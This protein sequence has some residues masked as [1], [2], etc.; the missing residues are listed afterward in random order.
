MASFLCAQKLYFYYSIFQ[1]N[2]HQNIRIL[3][4]LPRKNFNAISATALGDYR[5]ISVCEW[6][7]GVCTLGVA[8][9]K[10]HLYYCHNNGQ[11]AGSCGSGVVMGSACWLIKSI[12]LRAFKVSARWDGDIRRIMCTIVSIAISGNSWWIIMR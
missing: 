4:H 9:S 1:K 7:N 10:M 3:N 11:F 6:V 5:W 8:S 12:L 2:Y